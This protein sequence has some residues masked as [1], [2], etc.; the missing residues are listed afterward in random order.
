MSDSIIGWDKDA[1]GIVTL[2]IDDPDNGANMLTD[3]Y[4][5]QMGAMIDRLEAEV[6]E[7]T[8]V[9]ITSGKSTFF[10]GADL[11]QIRSAGPEHAQQLFDGSTAIK[12]DLRRLETLGKPVVAA[13]NGAALGGGLE[14]ALATHH[15]IA[16]NVAGSVIG[17][18][19]V[20]LGCCPVPAAWRAACGCS[21]SKTR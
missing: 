19:E 14:L 6:D 4:V 8:G 21:A 16:A 17:L 10:A 3:A 13:I 1:D 2:T 9:V 20:M 15:R 11:T 12:R 5:E 18:P 7:T